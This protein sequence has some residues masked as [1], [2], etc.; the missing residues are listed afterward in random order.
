ME[1]YSR[2]GAKSRIYSSYSQ[3]EKN[4]MN[5]N[6][7]IIKIVVINFTFSISLLKKSI[8][9]ELFTYNNREIWG[10]I[11]GGKSKSSEFESCEHQI[12]M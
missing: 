10:I 2:G 4:L 11:T 7:Y 6:F 9:V 1:A 12:S 8:P 3:I 5:V